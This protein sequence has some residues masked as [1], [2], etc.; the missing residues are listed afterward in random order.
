MYIASSR[1]F[2]II[3]NLGDRHTLP[4]QKCHQSSQHNEKAR[5]QCFWRLLEYSCRRSHYCCCSYGHEFHWQQAL[6]QKYTSLMDANS[7]IPS[8]RSCLWAYQSLTNLLTT[9]HF[10]SNTLNYHHHFWT[11]CSLTWWMEGDG[12]R[13]IRCWRYLDRE[14][15]GSVNL[16]KNCQHPRQIWQEHFLWPI[17]GAFKQ[18]RMLLIVRSDSVLSNTTSTRVLRRSSQRSA[19]D[20]WDYCKT[21]LISDSWYGYK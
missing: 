21:C 5:L 10:W 14:T 11:T 19:A 13:T 12:E 1:Y 17:H 18:G 16:V 9:T 6:I 20:L 7:S 15:K 2:L 3:D 8:R 4:P